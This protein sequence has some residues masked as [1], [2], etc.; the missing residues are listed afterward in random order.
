MNVLYI[1]TT[2][3]QSSLLTIGV[4]EEIAV[5]NS[6]E[7]T[8]NISIWRVDP[9]GQFWSIDAGAVGR[10]AIDIETELLNKVTQ[11]RKQKTQQMSENESQFGTRNLD[12]KSYLST[13][14][15]EE[16]LE[17][18]NDCLVNGIISSIKRGNHKQS[19]HTNGLLDILLLDAGLRR[20]L[21]SAIIRERPLGATRANP[22]IELVRC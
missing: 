1:T 6:N 5:N 13:L 18:A 10:A 3:P 8:S 14:T 9:T 11:W 2:H 17:V 21:K 7:A 4:N 15:V 19:L 12:V 20:R 22:S 16:A